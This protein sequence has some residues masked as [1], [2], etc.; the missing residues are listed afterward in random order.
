[1]AEQEQMIIRINSK[2]KT[3]ASSIAS[4]EGSNIS[5]LVR[6]LL[7]NYVRERDFTA[8]MKQ[9][10]KDLGKE[11]QATG[12]TLADVDDEIQAM[13]KEKRARRH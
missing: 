12:M 13:R 5:E 6:R 4:Q 8:H 1:M 7:E 2:L 11:L 10:W 3:K 9:L